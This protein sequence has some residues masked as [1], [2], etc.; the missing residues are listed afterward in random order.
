[1]NAQKFIYTRNVNILH[2]IY[3][4]AVANNESPADTVAEFVDNIGK[5][6]AIDTLATIINATSKF[7]SR[8]SKAVR[9]WASGHG[10]SN[11]FCEA[12][13]IYKPGWLHTTHLQQ[14]AES[15]MAL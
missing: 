6:A 5:D 1:M 4:P 8:L 7:D 13:L 11:E 15:A 10:L 3:S 12:H 2:D 9:V 14:L